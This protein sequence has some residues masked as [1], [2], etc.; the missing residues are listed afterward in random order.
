M[1]S[2]IKCLLEFEN[3]KSGVIQEILD[4][5]VEDKLIKKSELVGVDTHLDR[6]IFIH[7]KFKKLLESEELELAEFEW[8]ILPRH[9]IQITV[10]SAHRQVEFIYEGL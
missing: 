2:K 10:L 1:N 4:F 7:C 5:L 3:K 6:A 9:F 8:S